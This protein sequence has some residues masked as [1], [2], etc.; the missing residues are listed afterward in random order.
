MHG[1][2]DQSHSSHRSEPAARTGS[3]D[4]SVRSRLAKSLTL[5][6]ISLCYAVVQ[7]DVTTVNTALSSVGNSLGGGVS[8]LQ[9]VVT[10]Y[11]IAFAAL[12]LTA[13]ALGDRSGAKRIFMAGF[14]SHAC[15][16]Q[17]RRSRVIATGQT[18]G[19]AGSSLIGQLRSL[20][21]SGPLPQSRHWRP[22]E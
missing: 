18:V 13:G 11:T 8:E 17:S 22:C 9:W 5:G 19:I 20:D 12:I 21:I 3:V 14:A 7:L 6:G 4:K 15:L 10:A 16:P 2:T 1:A